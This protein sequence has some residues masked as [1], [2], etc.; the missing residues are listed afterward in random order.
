MKKTLITTAVLLLG[1]CAQQIGPDQYIANMY[2]KGTLKGYE[3]TGLNC[4]SSSCKASCPGCHI[5]NY[6]RVLL[7]VDE[8]LDESAKRLGEKVVD[9][10]L[11]TVVDSLNLINISETRDIP[12]ES[13]FTCSTV[14]EKE[15]SY[16][17]S[18]G[19]SE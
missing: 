10:C 14:F 18:M 7:T 17:K 13:E 5:K 9:S 4:T 3:E 16:L 1:A 2:A 8:V 12:A 15:K 19:F 11:V 6:D